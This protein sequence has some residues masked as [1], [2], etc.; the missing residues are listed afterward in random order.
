[1]LEATA[2]GLEAIAIRWEAI[3]I[4]N[5]TCFFLFGMQFNRFA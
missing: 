1:M 5:S 2:I 3:A 4:S